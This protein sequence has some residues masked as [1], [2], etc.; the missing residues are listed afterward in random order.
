MHPISFAM[1]TMHPFLLTMLTMLTT[2]LSMK[3]THSFAILAIFY[4]APNLIC[5]ACKN[6]EY[7]MHTISFS[8]LAM[9]TMHPISFA[10]LTMYQISFAMLTMLATI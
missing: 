1:L 7:Y 4:D 10:M 9:L 8:M 3:C 6:F 2:I 5:N